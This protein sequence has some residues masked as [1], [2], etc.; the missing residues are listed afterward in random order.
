MT[1]PRTQSSLRAKRSNPDYFRGYT[2]DCFVASLLAMTTSCEQ[3][4]H[5]PVGGD[6]LA[7]LVFQL[8]AIKP[9]AENPE[10]QA[11]LVLDAEVIAGQHLAVLL[12]PFHGDAL[13]PFHPRHHMVGAPP[14]EAMRRTVG[15]G[16]KRHLDRLGPRE[17]TQ[18]PQRRLAVGAASAC[19][20]GAARS[21]RSGMCVSCG[22]CTTTRREPI[23]AAMRSIS[24]AS[25]SLSW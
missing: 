25:S 20:A 24:A 12:P 22:I 17:Q 21:A 5:E 13:R 15:H 11:R 10:A 18:G 4:V 16:R 6:R 9:V 23:R 2:L 19:C 3:P 8:A 14:G 1:A 7:R